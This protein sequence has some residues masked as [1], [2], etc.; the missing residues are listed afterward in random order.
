MDVLI[1]N[2]ERTRLRLLAAPVSKE[3]ADL[4]RMRAKKETRGQNPSKA[5]LGL[6][7][8]TIFLTNIPVAKATFGEILGISG[9]G[10]ASR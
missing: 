9:R 8:W 7:D 2:R 4:R 5:M 10:G 6:V 3:I 1:N